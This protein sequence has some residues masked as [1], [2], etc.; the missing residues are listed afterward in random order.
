MPR[1]ARYRAIARELAQRIES[2]DL[3]PG[4]RLP[5]EE[6]LADRYAVHRL[7]ARQAMVELRTTGLVETRHGSGSYVRAVQRRFE[8]AIDPE[9]RLHRPGV[10][11]AV[12]A[13]FTG[14][15]ELR[16]AGL[17]ED[18]AGARALGLVGDEVWEVATL[19]RMDTVPCVASRY[20]LPPRLADLA[21]APEEG[22]LGALRRLGHDV[23][24]RSHTVSADLAGLEDRDAFQ[25]EPG[26]AV[27]VREGL[28]VEDEQPLCRVVRRCRGD[29]VAFTTHY[30]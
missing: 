18:P 2:G 16:A 24:Y 1:E 27:L 21:F 25:A 9:T 29:L 10:A 12:A 30:E 15:E 5:T 14:G 23:R 8:V 13:R 20:V 19:L 4:S 22:L 28:L 3:P 11:D 17:R 7:T 26:S 6:A